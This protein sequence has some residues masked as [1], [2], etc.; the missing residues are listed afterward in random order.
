MFEWLTETPYAA[1]VR[2]SWGWPLALTI[3]AFGNAVI[4]AFSFIMGMRLIGMFRTIPYTSPLK[5]FR[6]SA[7]FAAQ[8]FSGFTLWM[9]ADKYPCIG[10]VRGEILPASRRHPDLLFPER[11]AARGAAWASGKVSQL[12]C[13]LS[14]YGLGM[15]LGPDHGCLTAYLG[16]LYS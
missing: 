2:E 6:T 4:V 16:A 7:A 11:H 10:H 15:G 5:L 12:A 9:T 3:H 1:W 14:G 8:V 13:A